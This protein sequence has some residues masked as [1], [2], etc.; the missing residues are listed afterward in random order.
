M[1]YF[2]GHVFDSGS[3][4]VEEKMLKTKTGLAF[5]MSIDTWIKCIQ[6]GV[7][8]FNDY[9]YELGFYTYD[10]RQIGDSQL[11]RVELTPIRTDR[12]I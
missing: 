2:L 11:L 5:Y 8:L 9:Q 4:Y 6:H 3:F 10:V 7:I 1:I 12:G